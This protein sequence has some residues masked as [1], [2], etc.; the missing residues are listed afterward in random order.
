MVTYAFS[1]KRLYLIKLFKDKNETK[2]TTKVL[3]LLKFLY[4]YELNSFHN[5]SD[6]MIIKF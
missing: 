6:L 4:I 2:T 1:E 3:G 5:A